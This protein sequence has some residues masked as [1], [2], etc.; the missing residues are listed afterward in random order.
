MGKLGI[1]EQGAGDGRHDMAMEGRVGVC[2]L[3]GG[4]CAA[5]KSDGS[6]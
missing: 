2:E 3:V 6:G 4:G 1:A 5:E